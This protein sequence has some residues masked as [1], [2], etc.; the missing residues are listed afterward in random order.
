MRAETEVPPG[1]VQDHTRAKFPFSLYLIS[2]VRHTSALLLLA[3]SLHPVLSVG[4]GSAPTWKEAKAMLWREEK[5]KKEW[6]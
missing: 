5:K 2:C 4:V 1:N 6:W 3:K